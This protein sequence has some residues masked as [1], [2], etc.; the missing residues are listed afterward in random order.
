MMLKSLAGEF[1]ALTRNSLSVSLLACLLLN[2]PPSD[3]K[4]IHLV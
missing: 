3:G 1:R 2:L 4:P